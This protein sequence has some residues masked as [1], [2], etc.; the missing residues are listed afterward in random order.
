MGCKVGQVRRVG[1][2]GHDISGPHVELY[3]RASGPSTGVLYPNRDHRGGACTRQRSHGSRGART[4]ARAAGSRPAHID[5]SA[6]RLASL[7]VRSAARPAGFAA[8]APKT[9]LISIVSA[10]R[11]GTEGC[12]AHAREPTTCRS[13][14]TLSLFCVTLPNCQ[15]FQLCIAAYLCQLSELCNSA[16]LQ[17]A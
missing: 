14:F 6:G 17:R 7:F 10:L 11:A 16:T 15:L 9:D 12:A 1:K 8:H 13:V 2:V 5:R 3:P 4:Q